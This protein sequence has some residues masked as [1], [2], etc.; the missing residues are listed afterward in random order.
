MSVRR[1]SGLIVLALAGGLAACSHT[2]FD[3][4]TGG[5]SLLVGLGLAAPERE[6]IDYRTRAPLAA[7]PANA[8]TALRPPA[9][10][11]ATRPANWPT[12]PDALRRERERWARAN[13]MEAR[14]ARLR[15]LTPQEEIELMRRTAVGNGVPNSGNEGR[16]ET[17]QRDME[18]LRNPNSVTP[19]GSSIL[20]DI[21][22]SAVPQMRQSSAAAEAQENA[23]AERYGREQTA[24]F[25]RQRVDTTGLRRAEPPRRTLTDPPT[26]FRT[27][28]PE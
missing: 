5:N 24:E 28:A 11:G 14:D 23:L 10:A 20:T 6:T 3:S 19:T 18:I 13:P 12:D 15:G 4:A 22:P 26:G 2:S 16:H 21:D 9:E 27:P 1:L 25:A 17:A 8:Q 7:P